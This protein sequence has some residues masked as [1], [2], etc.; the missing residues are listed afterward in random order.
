MKD[1]AREAGG[2][3]LPML[4]LGPEMR[5][6]KEGRELYGMDYWLSQQDDKMS[7]NPRQLDGS[8]YWIPVSMPVGNREK[9]QWNFSWCE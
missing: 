9:G 4:Y 7:V 6:E 8:A 3:V 2:I 5:M 1:L